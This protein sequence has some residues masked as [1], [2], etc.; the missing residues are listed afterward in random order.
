MINFP[1]AAAPAPI[2]P[3]IGSHG[4]EGRHHSLSHCWRATMMLFGSMKAELVRACVR[5]CTPPRFVA[6]LMFQVP[7]RLELDSLS[8]VYRRRSMVHESNRQLHKPHKYTTVCR[9]RFRS[10]FFV[11]VRFHAT[12]INC[13]VFSAALGARRLSLGLRYLARLKALWH[14]R[15][16]SFPSSCS[17]AIIFASGYFSDFRWR[18][19][20]LLLHTNE[21]F[22]FLR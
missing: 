22:P 20:A 2:S 14:A 21:L 4:R 10:F 11:F 7:V 16:G 9:S 5:A 13:Q 17:W 1:T 12:N 6:N 8:G 19:V 15:I 3:S 18:R